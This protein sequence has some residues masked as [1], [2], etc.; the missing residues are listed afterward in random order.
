[1]KVEISNGEL[2]DKWTIL[3]IKMKRLTNET[4]AR[5]AAKELE[6][7]TEC[8]TKLEVSDDDIKALFE[9]NLALWDIEDKIRE[10][11]HLQEFDDIFIELARSV[12][13]FNDDRFAI[14]KRIN[15]YTG[16]LLVEEKQYTSYKED[17]DPCYGKASDQ[18][19]LNAAAKILKRV[20]GG[21]MFEIELGKNSK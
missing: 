2:I 20:T 18:E 10:K 13:L 9:V 12:Y 15:K 11:E 6:Y 3:T 1:M 19:V 21:G 14:K 17:G 4:A 7:L 16:S 8:T 5:N